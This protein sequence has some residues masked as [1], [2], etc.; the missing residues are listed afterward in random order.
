MIIL[1]KAVFSCYH[2]IFLCGLW[3]SDQCRNHQSWSLLNVKDGIHYQREEYLRVHQLRQDLQEQNYLLDQFLLNVHCQN[4]Y[5]IMLTLVNEFFSYY[6]H[7][8]LCGL[9]GSGQYRNH[10]CWSLLCAKHGNHFQF[11]AYLQ[12]HQLHQDLRQ[13]SN[14]L[15][16]FLQYDHDGNHYQ[17]KLTLVNEFFS[18]YL[19]NCL[20]GLC[21]SGQY[22]N[23][24]CWSLLCAKHGNHFQFL[25]YLQEHQLHQDLRQP[26]N[27]LEQFL[28]Y[29]HDGNHYQI[30]VHYQ[31]MHI[32]LCSL[33]G[34]SQCSNHLGSILRYEEE[35]DR[36]LRAWC[37]L[38]HQLH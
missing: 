15:E 21:G 26:S 12:E 38:E 13:P 16:Q 32:Y 36:F 30:L 2:R 31:F 29:D 34:R 6:L 25:A 11:L 37:L 14:H 33:C 3:R 35:C 24:L 22:R 17:I 9:C 7:I 28:Q 1:G 18:Y 10:L 19:R 4:L 23:H 27:H 5:Q 20:C 8:C